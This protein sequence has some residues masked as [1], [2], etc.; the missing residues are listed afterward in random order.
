MEQIKGFACTSAPAKV[1]AAGFLYKLR[2]T[3]QPSIIQGSDGAFYVVKFNGFPGSQ[4]LINEVVGAELIRQIGLPVPTWAKIQVSNDFLIE[5]SGTW[6]CDER[7]FIAPLPGI[8]FGSRLIEAPDDQ[9]TYQMI[10][11]SWIDRIDN[12]ADFLGILILD[13][14]TNNCDRRQA[15]FLSDDWGRL[16]ATFIDNDFMF[17][18]KFGND[19]TCPRRAMTHDLDIYQGLWD[20]Q[21]VREWLYRID[22]IDEETIRRILEDVPAEWADVT[23]RRHIFDQLRLRR[24]LLPRLLGETKDVLRSGYS[25]RYDSRP[26]YAM[27]PSPIPPAQL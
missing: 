17:G 2:G 6:F 24:S 19:L 10:P 11:H 18:G 16:H 13:L 20:E 23:T 3:S 27:E 22:A 5:N 14:W 21:S 9:R 12:R 4:G 15:V 25:V 8:H 26:R 7:C 1:S